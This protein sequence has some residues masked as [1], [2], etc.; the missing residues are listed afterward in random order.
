MEVDQLLNGEL[1]FESARLVGRRWLS[2]DFDKIVEIYSD[3]DVIRWIDDGNPL[4]PEDAQVWLDNTARNYKERGYGMFTLEDRV[5]HEVVGFIGL[6]H[7]DGQE[8]AEVKYAFGKPYWG[9]GLA[10][11]IVE[12]VVA[13]A[14]D[15][16]Q[17]PIMVATVAPEN[18][19]SQKVLTKVGFKFVE[20]RDD[21]YGE[22]E[23][24]YEWHGLAAPAA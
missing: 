14:A 12:A 15:T 7:P 19:A 21:E 4:T 1:L 2:S 11:E 22:T 18:H 5:S 10:S 8:Y 24:Y 6:V 9:R 17:L 16:L 20:Q 3:A 23:F 13:Y